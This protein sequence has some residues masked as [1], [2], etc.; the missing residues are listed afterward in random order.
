M[1]Y[2]IQISMLSFIGGLLFGILLGW[3][4]D[5]I[6]EVIEKRQNEKRSN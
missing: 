2:H 5:R 1:E 4:Q 6:K 3:T